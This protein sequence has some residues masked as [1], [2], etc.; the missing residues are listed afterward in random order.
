MKHSWVQKVGDLHVPW[1]KRESSARG[2]NHACAVRLRYKQCVIF[3]PDVI[4]TDKSYVNGVVGRIP[5]LCM[6]A[7]G[8]TGWCAMNQ[9]TRFRYS[10]WHSENVSGNLL[11]FIWQYLH[12][13]LCYV[14][15]QVMV[16]LESTVK[17]KIT[18]EHSLRPWHEKE[19]FPSW[20]RVGRILCCDYSTGQTV[21]V[22]NH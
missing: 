14:K 22:E 15:K 9:H 18:D 17:L 20:E 12:H 8:K 19:K 7:I 21:I 10:S 13:I 2:P 6:L 1:Q 11:N 5:L 16:L 4:Y 3:R